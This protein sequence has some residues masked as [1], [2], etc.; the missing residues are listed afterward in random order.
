MKSLSFDDNEDTFKKY[1]SLITIT[2]K[3]K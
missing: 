3:I 2:I 1:I